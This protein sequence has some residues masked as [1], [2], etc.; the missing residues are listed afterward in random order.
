MSY[1]KFHEEIARLIK[2]IEQLDEGAPTD[3][4]GLLPYMQGPIPV[5]LEQ[6]HVGNLIMID[7]G[8]WHYEEKKD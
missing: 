4:P 8:I 6:E 5:Y 1:A 7:T 2:G 3:F